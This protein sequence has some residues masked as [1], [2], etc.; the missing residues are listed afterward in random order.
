[1]RVSM[2]PPSRKKKHGP[3]FS[4][5]IEYTPHNP[6]F[7]THRGQKQ[8]NNDD[9]HRKPTE[10]AQNVPSP[11]DMVNIMKSYMRKYAL[12]FDSCNFWIGKWVSC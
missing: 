4:R 5:C 11:R 1:M 8:G 7:G 9:D 10:L 2:D 3:P 6:P 12:I